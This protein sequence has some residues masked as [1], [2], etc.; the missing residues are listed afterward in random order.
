MEESDNQF[1]VGTAEQVRSRWHVRLP[2]VNSLR[3]YLFS[4]SD[5]S[6]VP[7]PPAASTSTDFQRIR[8]DECRDKFEH[9]G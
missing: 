7:A 2:Q 6:R 5:G 4:T 1:Q 3:V 9:Q 8:R